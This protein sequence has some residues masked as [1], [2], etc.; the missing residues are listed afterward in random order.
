MMIE[1]LLAGLRQQAGSDYIGEPVSQLEHALLTARQAELAGASETLVLA[2]LLHDIGHWCQ[3]NAMQMDTLGTLNH[4]RLGASY[5]RKI[6]LD[7]KIAVLVELHVDAK[8][9]MA[10]KNPRYRDRLSAASTRTLIH[11]GGPMSPE[12][13]LSFEEHPLSSQALQLRAWDESAKEE[14]VVLP[15]VDDYRQMLLRNR[16]DVLNELQIE[17]WE[18]TGFLHLRGWYNRNEIDRLSK[19]TQSM[20]AWPETAGKWMKYF[21][22]PGSRQRLLC[23]IENFLAYQPLFNDTVLGSSTLNLLSQLMDEPAVLFKEKINF[24]LPGGQGFLA[25]QDAPAFSSFDQHYHITLMLSI[26]PMT[27]DNGC[28]EISDSVKHRS[29]LEMNDDLTLT[30]EVADQLKWQS[31]ETDP[32][33]LVLFDSYL[34]HRSGSNISNQSRRALFATYNRLIDGSWRDKYYSEKRLT[35]PPDVEKKPGITYNG[36]VFNVGNPVELE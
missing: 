8:R 23:R 29:L 7:E 20:A 31:V 25:H 10:A 32:G 24:K 36:G 28:L 9:Y 14:N 5:V 18:N 34:P 35:F 16:T 33:D 11:Q 27:I 30:T 4:E 13:M 3:P 19:A 6:G 21:E 17:A 26:D 12:E 15:E 22:N 2:A 1:N